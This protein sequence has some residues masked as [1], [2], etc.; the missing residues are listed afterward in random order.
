MNFGPL[1][2][3]IGSGVWGT[4][5]ISTSFACWLRYCTDVTQRSSTKL[6]TIFGRLPDWYTIYSFSGALAPKGIFASCKI[7][8]VQVL[9]SPIL[10]ALLHGTRAVGVGETL[11]RCAED[12]TYI[13]QGGRQEFLSRGSKNL[14]GPGPPPPRQSHWICTNTTSAI[15]RRW[16]SGPQDSPPVRCRCSETSSED[17]HLLTVILANTVTCPC[18]ESSRSGHFNRLFV[19]SFIDRTRMRANAQRDGRPAEHRWRPLFNAAA[20]FG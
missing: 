15:G 10:A 16:G 2:A 12:A 19:H 18:S 3:E 6:C 9:R 17:P 11:R 4:P 13:Q 5:Q 20:K 1:A 8:Y 7:H 14:R